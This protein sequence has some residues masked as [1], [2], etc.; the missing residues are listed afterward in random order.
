MDDV[1]QIMG[2]HRYGLMRS[3]WIESVEILD[4][5]LQTEILFDVYAAIS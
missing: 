4:V 5:R 1:Q 3:W 2:V